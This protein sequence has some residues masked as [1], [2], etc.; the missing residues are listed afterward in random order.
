MG[1]LNKLNSIMISSNS[2]SYDERHRNFL[3]YLVEPEEADVIIYGVPFDAGTQRHVGTNEGPIGIRR[4]LSFFRNWSSE[5]DLC[6]T[7]YI[8]T[9]DIGNVDMLWYDYEFTFKI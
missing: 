7:D 2:V 1:D 9:A 6:F 8:K 3:Q 5:L 4:A